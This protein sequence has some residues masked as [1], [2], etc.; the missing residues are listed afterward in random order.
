MEMNR[1]LSEVWSEFVFKGLAFNS[2]LY[3]YIQL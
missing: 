2:Q 1:V 3:M